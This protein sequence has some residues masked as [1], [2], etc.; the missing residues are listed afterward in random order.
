ME[1]S[2]RKGV[3]GV[4]AVQNG[5]GF[6]RYLRDSIYAD[7]AELTTKIDQRLADYLGEYLEFKN[8]QCPAN[9]FF[10]LINPIKAGGSVLTSYLPAK[11]KE[12]F[13]DIRE[14]EVLEVAVDLDL[15]LTPFVTD[16]NFMRYLSN[17]V[18]HLTNSLLDEE[19]I[20]IPELSQ[21]EFNTL[22]T[23]LEDLYNLQL[24]EVD[25]LFLW[26][27][28]ALN[29]HEQINDLIGIN[30]FKTD[31]EG[32]DR[33]SKPSLNTIAKRKSKNYVSAK[34]LSTYAVRCR[35]Y[36]LFKGH[37]LFPDLVYKTGPIEELFAKYN[38]SS[39]VRV[40]EIREITTNKLQRAQSLEKFDL[41]EKKIANFMADHLIAVDIP[42]PKNRTL[43][44]RYSSQGVST[45]LI[46]P[47]INSLRAQLKLDPNKSTR[48]AKV[49][50]P[51]EHL[52]VEIDDLKESELSKVEQALK[53]LLQ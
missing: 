12:I 11:I 18:R 43:E 14:N 30:D 33:Y 9:S 51:T 44:V 13:P 7:T 29:W 47:V 34:T 45:E 2:R 39:K 15:L 32:V 40:E 6:A 1:I 16:I 25:Q 37:T 31:K 48:K 53:A 10:S 23:K 35:M 46:T 41:A 19:L 21:K 36:V 20:E 52:S 5:K 26:I 8:M 50:S 4:E 42:F 28:K 38:K 24:R 3:S 17:A 22:K 49:N 27:E